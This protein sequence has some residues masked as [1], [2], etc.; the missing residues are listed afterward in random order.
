MDSVLSRPE[1]STAN[2]PVNVH[3]HLCPLGQEAGILTEF[4]IGCQNP[5]RQKNVLPLNFFLSYII[6][7]ARLNL[8]WA[9]YKFIC[10][11]GRGL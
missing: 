7:P 9:L 2:A 11:T 5:L 4:L 10:F 3:P 8:E 6:P 1:F